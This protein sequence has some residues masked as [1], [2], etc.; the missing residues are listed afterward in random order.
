MLVTEKAKNWNR[1]SS[2]D[3]YEQTF[4]NNQNEHKL[5]IYTISY[6]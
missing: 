6:Q 5:K 2:T 4:K 1:A 3:S